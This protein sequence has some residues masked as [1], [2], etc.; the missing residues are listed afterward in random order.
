M[1]RRQVMRKGDCEC[2]MAMAIAIVTLLIITSV[3]A[4]MIISSGTESAISGNFK[5]EQTAFYG[6][7]GGDEEVR[8]RL[9]SN[10]PGSSTLGANLPTGLPGS[11]H[12]V[13]YVLNPLN[14]ETDTPWDGSS[15]GQYYDDEIAKELGASQLN[16]N[17]WYTTTNA[18]STYALSPQLP[19]KW[20]RVMVKTNVNITPSGAGS[21]VDGIAGG[22][23]VD[24]SGTGAIGRRV[25]YNAI[26]KNE[27]SID[28]SVYPDCKSASPY[29]YAVYELTSL[30]VTPSGSRRMIQY[31]VASD[32]FPVMPSAMTFDGSSPNFATNPN[33]AAFKVKGT[34]LHS[35]TTNGYDQP[36]IGAYDAAGQSTITGQL[37][38]PS[39]YTGTGGTPSVSNVNSALGPVL[40]TV[41][42]LTQLVQSV[43]QA[44]GS[45]VYPSG[46]V[47][48]NLGTTTNPVINV[49]NG[50]LT[51]GGGTTG[52][53]IL[54]VTGTLTLNGNPSWNGIILVIGKGNVVKNGGGNGVL[55]GSM[56]VA[57]IYSDPPNYTTPIPLG[58][59]NAPGKPTVAWGGGGN[60]TFQYDSCWSTKFNTDFPY[61]TI[62]NRELVY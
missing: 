31:E 26:T 13:V 4:V 60:M 49:V 47:P 38:V 51:L 53:G 22:T 44:A 36:A 16:G 20:V 42:G 39:A 28:S 58:Q 61:R 45:N 7:R 24:G 54:L 8:D 48:T 15:H 30:A 11:P 37:N 33:S 21:I 59:N 50:D 35:C 25:C 52:S 40:S 17:S 1:R 34:D 18:S 10:S 19:W 27:V 23:F 62:S 41:D 56:L 5:D 29:D 57:D 3:V 2:G 6:A 46:T 12:Q 14:S 55:T 43:T 32:G 9:R